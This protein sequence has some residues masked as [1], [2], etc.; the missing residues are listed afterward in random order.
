MNLEDRVAAIVET[1]LASS[2]EGSVYTFP[3]DHAKQFSLDLLD[4]IELEIAL[5]EEF[6][7]NIT[8]EESERH[9]KSVNSIAAFLRTK[10]FN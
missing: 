2:K 5:E 6:C 4:L 9:L 3:I 8:Q 7:F 10:G 1:T